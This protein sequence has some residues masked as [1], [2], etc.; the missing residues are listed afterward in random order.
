MVCKLI[1]MD[2][3]VGRKSS[4]GV[5]DN[6]AAVGAGGRLG[7]GA[8]QCRTYKDLSWWCKN[9]PS[10]LQAVP[11]RNAS[12]FIFYF[13]I[14]VIVVGLGDSNFYTSFFMDLRISL[15]HSL[16]LQMRDSKEARKQEIWRKGIECLKVQNNLSQKA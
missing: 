15:P 6:T 13:V 14:T 5:K 7:A 3:P 8:L 11:A 10:E 1:N 16:P 12:T 4:A 2:R 9:L